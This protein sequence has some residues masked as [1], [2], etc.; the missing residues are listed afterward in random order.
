[1]TIEAFEVTAVLYEVGKADCNAA[2]PRDVTVLPR[3]K[4]SFRQNSR[5]K[6]QFMI[7]YVTVTATKATVCRLELEYIRV[8]NPREA[9]K[10]RW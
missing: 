4:C 10:L 8:R 5:A 1:M 9:E 2:A 3:G 6:R 7:L